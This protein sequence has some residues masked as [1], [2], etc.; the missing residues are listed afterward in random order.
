ME[1]TNCGDDCPMVKCGFCKCDKECP[2]YNESWWLE[3]KTQEQKLVKDCI[4][5]RL[6]IQSNLQQQ[7]IDGLQCALEEQRNTFLTMGQNFAVL[8]NAVKELVEATPHIQNKQTHE[9]E[10]KTKD[11]ESSPKH[12]D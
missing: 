1:N 6:M 3:A 10:D 7:R 8:L 12:Q 9:I 2:N 5:K 11:E 4:P